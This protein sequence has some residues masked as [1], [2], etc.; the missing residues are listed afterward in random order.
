MVLRLG[1]LNHAKGFVLNKLLE[2]GRLG[3]RHISVHDLPSG[4]PPSWRH[5]IPQAVDA[6]KREGIIQVSPKRTGRGSADHVSLVK[7]RI[8]E[9]RGLLNA[10][11]ETVGLP[12]FGRDLRTMLQW[13]E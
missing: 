7:D 4:Y 2:Q 6:L 10:Y 9:A 13:T 12:R 8:A 11:R 1:S 5:L 3:A